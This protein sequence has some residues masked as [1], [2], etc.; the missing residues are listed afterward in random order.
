V[1]FLEAITENVQ[2]STP[3]TDAD[4]ARMLQVIRG[5]G[6]DDPL[7]EPEPEPEPVPVAVP[8]PAP[9]PVEPV[10]PVEPVAVEAAPAARKRG[11]GRPTKAE[12][13][14][15]RQAMAASFSD[16]AVEP[17]AASAPPSGEARVPQAPSRFT[18]GK[19]HSPAVVALAAALLPVFA[20]DPD[21]AASNLEAAVNMAWTALNR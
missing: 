16:E 6:A 14:A 1:E 21:N 11:P 19:K 10:E 7:P 13:E 18:I 4:V 3:W 12:M 5:A 15:K 17:V 9:V 2:V 20:D 8:A